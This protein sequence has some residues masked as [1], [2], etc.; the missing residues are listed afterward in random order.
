M[1]TIKVD[2]TRS[3]QRVDALGKQLG[4]RNIE[5][6]QRVLSR[7]TLLGASATIARTA[8][9][10]KRVQRKAPGLKWPHKVM[11]EGSLQDANKEQTRA[12]V[13]D[14]VL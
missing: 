10:Q 6:L 2:D 13:W 3:P 9:C 1:Y 5:V 12:V 11:L 7:R 14:P 8:T 4:H